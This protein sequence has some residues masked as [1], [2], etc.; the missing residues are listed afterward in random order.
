MKIEQMKVSQLLGRSEAG[1][2]A[3]P[4]FQREFVWDAKR[5]TKLL[6]SMYRGMP[7]GYILVWKAPPRFRYYFRKSNGVLPP[8]NPKNREIW[9]IIDGQQRLGVIYQALRGGTIINSNDITVDFTHICYALD[10]RDEGR[11][12]LM[13]NPMADRFVRV[14]DI[15]DPEWRKRI[16]HLPFYKQQRIAQ[17]R[18]R[19]LG[20]RIP[21]LFVKT[22]SNRDIEETFLRINSGGMRISTADIVFARA[23]R[24]NLRRLVNELRSGLPYGFRYVPRRTIQFAASLMMGLREVSGRAI[25]AF[26]DRKGRQ[27]IVDG[28]VSDEFNADWQKIHQSITKAVDYLISALGVPNYEFLPSD[29]LLATLAFFFHANSCA[30]PTS[31]QAR[32]LTK[33]FW[34]TAV[35]GRYSGRGY[36]NNIIADIKYFAKLSEKPSTHFKFNDRV[37]VND[38][39]RAEY[40][41][42]SSLT[43]AF[44]LL[45]CQ[46]RPLYIENARPIPLGETASV[47][48]RNDKHHIF[49]KALLK[50]NGF[51]DREADR[52]C[53]ICF[54][55]AEDNQSFGSKAPRRYLA[56]FKSR[57]NFPRVM[58][59]HLIPHFKGSG[60]WKSNIRR[61]YRTFL[62]QRAQ[63][64]INA[65]EKQAGICLFRKD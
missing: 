31:R 50:R 19:L 65:F 21:V 27:Y 35:R 40:R 30:Q 57:R 23:S 36:F 9:Y 25:E 64:V 60:L 43:A 42:V 10:G 49:P 15:L 16:K 26:L 1:Y 29:N 2:F 34:A 61:G 39:L 55:V 28:R 13:R 18:S 12:E 14:C 38:L 5:A 4:E 7:I 54:M 6:D 56:N 59:S 45:L 3:V 58:R 8:H 32:E 37:L 46:Q 11:F 20:Y 48:N 17:C 62:E 53:N 22:N 44:F 52:L 33:W 24:L 51:T 47:K 41:G 63:V